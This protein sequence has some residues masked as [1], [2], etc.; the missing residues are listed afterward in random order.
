G[1]ALGAPAGPGTVVAVALG[2]VLRDSQ[3]GG[4]G[5]VLQL[6]PLLVQ[7][8]GVDDERADPDQHHHHD[9]DEREHRAA[10]ATVAADA[11]LPHSPHRIAPV[12]DSVI[13]PNEPDPRRFPSAGTNVNSSVTVTLAC[14]RVS[15][16]DPSGQ[17]WT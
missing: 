17:L 9:R 10:I 4:I 1:G 11:T 6:P 16:L 5:T 13:V 14:W 15:P 3:R 8:P 7:R 12:A 2:A